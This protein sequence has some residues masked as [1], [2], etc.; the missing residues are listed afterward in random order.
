MSW[1]IIRFIQV[2]YLQ[3]KL[4][5]YSS[6]LTIVQIWLVQIFC[7]SV[8]S[9]YKIKILVHKSSIQF[10]VSVLFLVDEGKTEPLRPPLDSDALLSR[11]LLELDTLKTPTS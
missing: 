10:N 7:Q 5:S 11:H 1:S 8:P 9:L 4:R 6:N 3:T 2:D